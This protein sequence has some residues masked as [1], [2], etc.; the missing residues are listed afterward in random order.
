MSGKKKTLSAILS[1]VLFWFVVL[2]F[3]AIGGM[4]LGQRG[5]LYVPDRTTPNPVIAGLPSMQVVSVTTED[6]LTLSGWF[7]PP[8]DN[9][10]VVLMFHGNGGNQGIRGY[11][12][13]PYTTS[14]YGFLFGTYRGYGGN[15]GKPSEQGLYK[16]ARAW[17]KWLIDNKGYKQQ[18]IIMHGESLGSG[19]SIHTALEYPDIRAMILESPYTSFVDLGR[20]HYPFAPVN[21]LLKDRYESKN[22]IGKLNIPILIIHGKLDNVVPYSQGKELYGLANEPKEM[23]T[24]PI[25]GHND[26]YIFDTAQEILNY[27]SRL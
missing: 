14:G 8:K 21:L 25:A 24:L 10:P 17:M 6:G 7:Q 5:M 11:K 27:L 18:D 23:V 15:P 1:S 22:K 26:L 20:K 9:K 2:Y 3:A 19:V 13:L 12:V 16:D 4:Y